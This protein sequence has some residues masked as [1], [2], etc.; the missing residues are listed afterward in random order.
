MAR[1]KRCRRKVG[2][3]AAVRKHCDICEERLRIAKELVAI[4]TDQGAAATF[5][6][7]IAMVRP[8]DPYMGSIGSCSMAITYGFQKKEQ[9]MLS[10]VA[11]GQLDRAKEMV[12][13]YVQPYSRLLENLTREGVDSFRHEIPAYCDKLRATQDL[14]D[15]ILKGDAKRLEGAKRDIRN[16]IAHCEKELNGTISDYE[17]A[18]DP[19]IACASIMA[20]LSRE[21]YGGSISNKQDV[22]EWVAKITSGSTA[23]SCRAMQTI[24]EHWTGGSGYPLLSHLCW[25]ISRSDGADRANALLAA[26][27]NIPDECHNY[28]R[29]LIALGVGDLQKAKEM[30]CLVPLSYFTAD[31]ETKLAVAFFQTKDFVNAFWA[32]LGFDPFQCG[33]QYSVLHF[34]PYTVGEP[35]VVDVF[36]AVRSAK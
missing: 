14:C 30:L 29:F 15:G 24:N 17:F 19:K 36:F 32:L 34:A 12:A 35:R 18:R 10:M 13:A 16:V 9:I 8:D 31:A 7:L 21:I 23:D 27:Q 5:E 28:C 33:R 22:D 4:H 3:L 26:T 20:M 6:R 25:Q 1:C 2:I 11:A